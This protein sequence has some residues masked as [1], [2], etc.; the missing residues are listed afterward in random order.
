MTRSIVLALVRTT[1]PLSSLVAGTLSASVVAVSQGVFSW[2]WLAAGTAMT[3]LAMFGF[4]VNDV[5]DRDKDAKAGVR[6]PVATGE[7]TRR[8]ALLFAG[9]LLL[10]AFLVSPARGAADG[11]LAATSLGLLAY[12]PLALRFP[13]GKGVYVALLCCLPLLYGSVI[14]GVQRSWL[15]YAALSVFIA[16]REIWMDADEMEGDLRAG[17]KTIAAWIGQER[18]RRTG[19]ALMLVSAACLA[20][21]ERGSIGRISALAMLLSFAAVVFWPGLSDS[22]R[23]QL[24]RLPMLIGAVALACGE[25]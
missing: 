19:I 7:I 21:I 3:L 23:I 14:A 6:R 11:V 16:G 9:G 1:R 22:R 4:V 5:V 24:S 25:G 13:A 12:S 18:T 8:I 15:V 10:A 17:V 20:G 2:V